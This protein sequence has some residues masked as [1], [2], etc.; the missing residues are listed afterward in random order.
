MRTPHDQEH[1]SKIHCLVPPLSSRTVQRVCNMHIPLSE[2]TRDK[3]SPATERRDLRAVLVT[4]YVYAQLLHWMG[5]PLYLP[6]L[7]LEWPPHLIFGL[8]RDVFPSLRMFVLFAPEA[9]T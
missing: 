7:C 1:M 6:K 4:L 5:L 3:F 8:A 2:R 9:H